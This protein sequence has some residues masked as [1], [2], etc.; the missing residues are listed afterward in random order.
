MTLTPPLAALTASENHL[1]VR[2]HDPGVAQ[3]ILANPQQRNAMSGPMTEAWSLVMSELASIPA[4]RCVLVTGEGRAFCAGGDL[5]WLAERGSY[6]VADLS[7]RMDD[8]YAAWLA[9][10]DLPVPTVAHIDGPAVG[11]GA[12]VALACDIRWVG[13]A[14]RFSVP[15]TRLGLHAGMGTTYLL[16]QAAGPAMARDLLLT[17]RSLD[18]GA[19][20][21][22]GLATESVAVV[23]V[24]GRVRQIAANAPI[25]TRLTKRGLSPDVP[26]S[27]REALRWEGL[28]QPVTMTTEDV[29]EGIA[30]ARER[31]EPVFRGR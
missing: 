2:W 5:G 15:F 16:A 11:A 22:C 1:L 25:A 24:P 10:G 7:R 18:A 3:V 31:R 12:A 21:A 17:G 19:M 29:Q 8:F 20:L 13:P 14:A 26:R 6:A 30:A 23:D 28:A 9:I 4:L 27:L